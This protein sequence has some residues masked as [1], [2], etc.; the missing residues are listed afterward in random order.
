MNNLDFLI[1]LTL[2]LTCQH[3]FKTHKYQLET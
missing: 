3:T 2:T 1:I